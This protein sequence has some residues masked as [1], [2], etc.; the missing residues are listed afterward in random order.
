MFY[1]DLIEEV[2]EVATTNPA[3]D[4]LKQGAGKTSTHCHSVTQTAFRFSDI[5]DNVIKNG[6]ESSY[7]QRDVLVIPVQR[8]PAD[9]H[10]KPC[11]LFFLNLES[12]IWNVH[13]LCLSCVCVCCN[14]RQRNPAKPNSLRWFKIFVC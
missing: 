7:W 6:P 1:V 12:Y 4:R 5:N 8:A 9:S 3:A 14:L 10:G 2:P 13:P 11:A